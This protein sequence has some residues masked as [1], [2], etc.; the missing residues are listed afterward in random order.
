ME[1]EAGRLPVLHDREAWE[2]SGMR[3]IAFVERRQ[4]RVNSFGVA[5]KRKT[6]QLEKVMAGNKNLRQQ[7]PRSG[8][9]ASK[10]GIQQGE[11]K[12][13]TVH[14]QNAASDG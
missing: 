11:R 1:N 2:K 13:V 7:P 14:H 10:V 5:L 6:R 4:A 8:I 3:T 12:S 9:Q